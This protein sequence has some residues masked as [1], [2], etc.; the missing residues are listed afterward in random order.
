[1]KTYL[2]STLMVIILPTRHLLQILRYLS[3]REREKCSSWHYGQQTDRLLAPCPCEDWKP[4]C[5]V[6]NRTMM[7]RT[8][9]SLK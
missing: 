2:T 6:P 1:M 5:P 7:V 4:S 8:T 9:L 3:F